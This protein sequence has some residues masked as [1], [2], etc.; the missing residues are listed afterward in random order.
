MIWVHEASVVK[1]R[2]SMR[3]IDERLEAAP[4]AP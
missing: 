1:L 4:D 3:E 2:S